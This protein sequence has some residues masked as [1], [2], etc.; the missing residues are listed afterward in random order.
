MEKIVQSSEATSFYTV[1]SRRFLTMFGIISVNYSEIYIDLNLLECPYQDL[2]VCD[3]EKTPLFSVEA[4][5]QMVAENHRSKSESYSHRIP[6]SK[7]PT[8]T[9]LHFNQKILV[10]IELSCF[11]L[12]GN[13]FL[14]WSVVS[15]WKY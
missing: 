8:L 3:V 2:R 11:K 10:Y 7:K 6:K 4:H 5:I 15:D 13:I 1:Y 12:Q 9:R 14:C